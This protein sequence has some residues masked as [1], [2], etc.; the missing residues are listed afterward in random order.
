MPQK[1][2]ANN[3]ENVDKTNLYKIQLNKINSLRMIK[4]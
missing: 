2:Y 3:F 4:P 1:L